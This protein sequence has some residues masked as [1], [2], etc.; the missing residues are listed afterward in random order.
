[1]K[2]FRYLLLSLTI[3]ASG[4]S[5]TP[6]TG[7]KKL[8]LISQEEEIK[9]GS[10]AYKEILSKERILNNQLA[11]EVEAIGKKIAA[12][13][14]RRDFHWEFKTIDNNVPN[15]FCLPGGKVVFHSGMAKI[16]T[17]YDQVAAVL[18]HEIGHAL[19]RHAGQR[20]TV[21]Y[22]RDAI[23]GILSVTTLAALKNRDKN[24]LFAALGIG[25]TIGIIL[26]YSRDNELEADEIGVVLMSRAGY[27]PRAALLLWKKMA[28]M[29]E[30][31]S[32]LPFLSTHPSSVKRQE[33][34]RELLP[35]LQKN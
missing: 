25:T 35:Q 31:R 21:Q 9:L 12:V 20:L 27:D 2:I 11:H 16:A 28:K 5:T 26:P 10:N 29:E 8:I 15:A 19:A 30:G 33:R 3:L 7:S 1:M 23:L 6:I 34:I 4:C 17:T 13:S 24:L 32:Q 14:G 18:G 22:G